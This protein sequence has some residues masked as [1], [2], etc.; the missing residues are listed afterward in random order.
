MKSRVGFAVVKVKS[1]VGFA[2]FPRVDGVTWRKDVLFTWNGREGKGR[3]S[4]FFRALQYGVTHTGHDLVE[5]EVCSGASTDVWFGA[6]HDPLFGHANWKASFCSPL[7]HR[8]HYLGYLLFINTRQRSLIQG[9][10][11]PRVVG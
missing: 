2:V 4:P 11:N 6:R 5:K 7:T 9:R 8:C 10:K 1:R 3:A